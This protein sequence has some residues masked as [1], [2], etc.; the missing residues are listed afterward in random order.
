MSSVEPK[1]LYQQIADQIR[2]MIQDETFPVGARLPSERELA[3]Q[4]GVSRPSLREGLIA[5]ELQGL[6]EI[7]VGSGVYVLAERSAT[8]PAVPYMGDS[9]SELMKARAVLEGSVAALAAG[10]FSDEALGKLNDII[11]EMESAISQ[12]TNPL[13]HDRR[14]H[15]MIASQCGNSVLERIV[16]SLFDER[17][18]PMSERLQDRFG[19]PETWIMALQEHK[20]IYNALSRKDI[21]LA[22]ASMRVHLEA[23]RLRWTE[24]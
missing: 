23:S 1:K 22:E 11:G 13:E 10:Q 3:Q 14:F 4:L 21:V 24:S 9:P 18:S 7:K 12:G 16:A 19:S 6:V 2:T 5:L 20:M 8:P 17:H 15:L